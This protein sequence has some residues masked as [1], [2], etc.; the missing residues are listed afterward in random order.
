MADNRKTPQEILNDIF[1]HKP[2][3][4][5]WRQSIGRP[6][7]NKHLYAEIVS[8]ILHRLNDAVT[9]GVTSICFNHRDLGWMIDP[10]KTLALWGYKVEKGEDFQS[11]IISYGT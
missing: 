1:G 9:D 8:K 6:Q 11:F 5:P 2:K 10:C 7:Q 4:S 3:P